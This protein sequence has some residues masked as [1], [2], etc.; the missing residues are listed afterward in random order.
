M[1]ATTTFVIVGASLAGAKAAEALRDAGFDGR[2]VLIG[3]EA[4]RPYER[5]PLSKDY[6]QGKVE[7]ESIH[8]HPES[9]YPEH[10]VELRL[11]TRVVAIDRGTHAVVTEAGD[12]IA[13]DRLLLT[14]GSS[15]VPLPVPGGTAPGVLYLRRVEDSDRLRSAFA[16]A[17]RVVIVGAGWIG[18]ETAAAARLAGAQVTVLEA[19]ELPLLRV[20][21]PECARVFAELHRRHGVEIRGNQRVEEVVLRDGR[22]VGVR[23]AGGEVV[24]ADVVVVGIGIR[25]NVELAQSAG[26]EVENGIKVDASL[27]TNDS[28]IFAAGDVAN[29]FNTLLGRYLRIEHWENAIE[30]P[31][32]AARAMMGEAVQWDRVPYFYT[33]QYE[34]GMEYAGWVQ[35][36]DYDQVVFRG[37]V[38]R[39]EF[40]AFWLVEGRVAAGMNVN[41]WD[42][43][44]A[45]KD[46]V[47]SRGRVERSR[48][49]DPSVPLEEL[50]PH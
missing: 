44:D 40:I 21:G 35:P 39:M 49:A 27:R 45:I 18:L 5:P 37:D 23:L 30:Q 32:L 4:V 20:L 15:P 9:W 31:K 25:P 11:A 7:P 14:T 17:G 3:E 33:D 41:V 2:I 42:V 8:V 46:M 36:P 6:L 1:T 13:Y 16:S 22:P 48:L 50:V 12:R 47:R 19:L 38:E 43:N 24:A 34:L 10:G 29:A 28:D 26:L